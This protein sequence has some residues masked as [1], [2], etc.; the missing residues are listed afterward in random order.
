MSEHGTNRGPG[1]PSTSEQVGEGIGGV[2]GTVAGAG[3][4]AAA[5]PVGSIIGGLAGAL[6]G[7]WIGEH[8]G[9]ALDDWHDHEAHYRDH[10]R[11]SGESKLGFEH[12]RVGYAVGH[13]AGQNPNWEG[14]PF[15]EVEDVLREHWNHGQHGYTRLRPYVR[16]GYRR[17][18]DP[19]ADPI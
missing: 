2:S 12:A 6:G 18:S 8:V 17:A 13:V 9:R 15:E 7:W 3:I 5:G 10:L 16:E 14:R 1:A 19:G 11:Q 4:G